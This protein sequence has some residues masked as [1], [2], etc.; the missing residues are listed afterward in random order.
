MLKVNNDN[1]FDVYEAVHCYASLWHEGQASTLY[2]ILSMSE[3]RPGPLWSES[4]CEKENDY[5]GMIESPEHC[6][7]LAIELGILTSEESE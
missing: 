7:K 3:F 6:E 5:F 2:S 1:R 4:R